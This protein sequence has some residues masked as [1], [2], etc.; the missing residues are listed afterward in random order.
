MG[1]VPRSWL[2]ALSDGIVKLDLNGTIIFA[3]EA[4]CRMTGYTVAQM[5]GRRKHSLLHHSYLDGRRHPAPQCAIRVALTR[6]ARFALARELFWRRDGTPFWADVIG[7]RVASGDLEAGS[8]PDRRHRKEDEEVAALLVLRPIA[9]GVGSA[10]PDDAIQS[11]D[12]PARARSEARA[13]EFA[14]GQV[15]RGVAGEL[16]TWSAQLAGYGKILSRHLP[17][18][19]PLLVPARAIQQMARVAQAFSHVLTAAAGAPRPL[20]DHPAHLA[21]TLHARRSA[22]ATAGALRRRD[23]SHLQAPAVLAIDS[24]PAWRD[25]AR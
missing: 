13:A 14:A 18:R 24:A 21:A 12:A 8:H 10:A 23:A 6:G 5:V 2:D 4:A 1:S 20:L 3:N 25:S 19:D 7:M 22:V 15:A 11:E 16:T 9:A 17:S